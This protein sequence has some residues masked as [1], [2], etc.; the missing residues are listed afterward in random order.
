MAN[1]REFEF[2]GFDEEP[3]GKYKQPKPHNAS[4]KQGYPV[5]ETNLNGTKTYGRYVDNGYFGTKKDTIEI[6]GCR[7]TSRGKHY[8]EDDTGRDTTPRTQAKR[9]K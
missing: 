9:G 7:N 2:F 8:H 4:V 6:R 1:K 3:I 5:D